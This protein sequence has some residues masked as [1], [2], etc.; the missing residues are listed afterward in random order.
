MQKWQTDMSLLAKM[1]PFTG[2]LM[3]ILAPVRPIVDGPSNI[4]LFFPFPVDVTCHLSF[5][6]P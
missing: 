4:R 6:Q 2:A 3:V 1:L 5:E